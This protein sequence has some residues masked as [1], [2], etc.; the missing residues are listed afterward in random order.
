MLEACRVTINPDPFHKVLQP[1]YTAY[2]KCLDLDLDLD[3]FVMEIKK[4]DFHNPG[5]YS[6]L[7]K[8]SKQMKLIYDMLVST[9]I[10]KPRVCSLLA[11]GIRVKFAWS[12]IVR[13]KLLL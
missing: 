10:S 12:Y 11:N 1:D 9:H 6:D 5:A 8:T 2:T 3:L 4:E 13:N 7:N